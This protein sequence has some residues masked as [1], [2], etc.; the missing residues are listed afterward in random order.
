MGSFLLVF[1]ILLVINFPAC[2]P[3]H[4]AAISNRWLAGCTVLEKAE[5]R[6]Q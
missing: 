5:L 3:A 2:F 4:N 6:S 1:E